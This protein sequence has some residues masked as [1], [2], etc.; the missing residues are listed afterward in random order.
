MQL[1]NEY[2]SIYHVM[3][4]YK[5]SYSDVIWQ[6]QCTG[7]CTDGCRHGV[8]KLARRCSRSKTL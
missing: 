8:M 6:V 7:R 2:R 1:V 5:W 3:Y 4:L